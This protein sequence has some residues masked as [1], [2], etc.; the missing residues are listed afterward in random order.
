ML[1]GLDVVQNLLRFGGT[2]QNRCDLVVVQQPGKGHLG[3]GLTALPGKVIQGA[4]LR[5]ALTQSR[6]PASGQFIGGARSYTVLAGDY[7][8]QVSTNLV[9]AQGQTAYSAARLDTFEQIEAQDG[10]DTDQEMQTLLQ[11]EQAYAAN[12]KVVQSVDEM[13]RIL[14]D[15]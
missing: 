4:D 6:A 10:V 14:M 13:L 9:R 3:Q 8:S 12:A 2:D 5:K 7:L 1:H 11:I 15:L